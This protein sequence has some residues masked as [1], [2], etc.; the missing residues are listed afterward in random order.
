MG[1]VVL[2]GC[3]GDD[4]TEPTDQELA[5]GQQIFRFDTFGDETFWTDTLRIHEVIQ[6]AVSPLTA[7]GVG[8][9]V[10]ADVLPPGTLETADL[11]HPATTIALLKLNAVVGLQGTVTNVNGKDTLTRVG[12]TCA[13]CHSTVDNSVQPGIGRRLDGW[14]NLDLNPGA[15]IAL[16][17]ALTPEQ[18][19]VYNSWGP[20]KYDARFNF[21]GQNDPAVIPPA[22]G[23]AGVN[24]VTFT[25]DGD[26]PAY[27][28]RYVAVTQMHGHGSFAEPRLNISVNNPPDQVESKL[29]ALEAYQLSLA[30]PEPPSGS[31]DAAAAERGRS[32]FATEGQCAT[33]H[34][35][36]KF[37]DANVRLHSPAEVP[38]DPTHAERSATGMYRTT[39]LRAL[40]QHA[41]YFHDGSAA[42]L[43]D[44][45]ERYDAASGLG[46]TAAEKVD[47]VE[48]L[49][50]L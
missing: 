43:A 16:S 28:N 20:G 7:L 12:V 33:C 32:V 15:I 34:T 44:V 3:G 29:A 23:L 41:P 27:W 25:G 19:A 31:F 42:T 30:A 9:K 5:E 26:R 6:S 21:D 48:Y 10:D 49:K 24:S 17:P 45:V 47:L 39:P 50:S 38:T 18:K 46:L 11:N 40:W 35:G 14:P 36:D 2:A 1:L 13:L 37:T 8:L 22:Y 4:I